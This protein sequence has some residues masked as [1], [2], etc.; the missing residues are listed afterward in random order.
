[1]NFRSYQPIINFSKYLRPDQTCEANCNLG[2]S[3]FLPRI[4]LH[5][6]DHEL[7]ANLIQI[8]D[9]ALKLNIDLSEFAILA[10]TRGRMKSYGKSNGLC[11]ITNILYKNKIK[12]I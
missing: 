6:D 4:I 10:P 12:F 11:L 2:T 9:D 5:R 3:K 7:E 1:M 8:L